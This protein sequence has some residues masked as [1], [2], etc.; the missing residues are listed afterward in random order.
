MA[1]DN[2]YSVSQIKDLLAKVHDLPVIP[3]GTSVNDLP[4]STA[5]YMGSSRPDAPPGMTV[6][7][8]ETYSVSATSRMQ[9]ATSWL[10]KMWTRA[11]GPTATVYGSWVEI[12]NAVSVSIVGASVSMDTL[13]KNSITMYTAAPNGAPLGVGPCRVDTMSFSDMTSNSQQ[14][15]IGDDGT[16]Y[17]RR[18]AGS[19]WSS[20]T[21]RT[22]PKTK[23]NTNGSGRKVVPLAINMPGSTLS[24]S[25]TSGTV[26]WIRSW[27]HAPSRI[28]IHI[29]NANPGSFSSGSAAN[30]EAVNIS[31]SDAQG[32]V[33]NIVSSRL[34]API[35]GYGNSIVTEWLTPEKLSDGGYLAITLRWSGSTT[36][37]R[38][39]GG[40]WTHAT[41][42]VTSPNVTGWT[43]SATSPFFVW[44]EAEVS[45]NVPIFLVNGDSISIGT[46]TTNPVQDSWPAIYG[47][48]VGAVPVYL[49]QH[50]SAMSS[51]VSS[52]PRW[53]M[54]E[55]FDLPSIVDSVVMCLGQ[56]DLGASGITLSDLKSRYY[57]LVGYL[58]YIFPE[59]SLYLAEVT[60]SNKATELEALRRDYNSWLSTLPSGERGLIRWATALSAQGLDEDLDPK[61]TTDLLH[62][63][64]LGQEVMASIVKGFKLMPTTLPSDILDRLYSSA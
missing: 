13:P 39:Y 5:Y 35:G 37:M 38:N 1:K 31:T 9:R 30:L 21:S 18:Y 43:Y 32:N 24:D 62:P 26:R 7:V 64:N 4:Q 12:G 10:G 56:N 61:Y 47:R 54:Y 8:I 28:R 22:I 55:N 23:N 51:W 46:N 40:C 41:A 50:G 53:K 6:G 44:I 16:M 49:S 2:F 33:A 34:T 29:S 11:K 15:L 14:T 27:A 60:P 63:N 52:S 19:S 57:D 45:K 17:V 3:A 36:V 25:S 58:Q 59:A 48:K 20:W 42:S